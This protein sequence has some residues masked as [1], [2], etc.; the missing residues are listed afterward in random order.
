MV[1]ATL[2]RVIASLHH[3]AEAVAA[4]LLAVIFVAFLVQITLRYLFNWP[5]GWTSD[6]SLAAWLWLV[7][8]G[9]R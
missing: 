5:V 2:H 7:R 3:F 4:G 8:G 9:S 6:L 1:R